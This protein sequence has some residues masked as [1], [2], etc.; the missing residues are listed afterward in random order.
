MSLLLRF[1]RFATSLATRRRFAPLGFGASS[2]VASTL[3]RA[4]GR[5]VDFRVAGGALQLLWVLVL[6]VSIM[7]KLLKG[8]VS[9]PRT[10]A[11]IFI[12]IDDISSCISFVLFLGFVT[13]GV[14]VLWSLGMV[15]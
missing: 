7:E 8:C 11:V 2:L 14:F 6:V 4:L 10:C 12:F 13:L 9:L 15:R 3:L 1:G 5:A